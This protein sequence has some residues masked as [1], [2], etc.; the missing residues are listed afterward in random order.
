MYTGI[1]SRNPRN[2][3]L[4]PRNTAHFSLS[5]TRE[6]CVHAKYLRSQYNDTKE[7]A[8]FWN[9]ESNKVSTCSQYQSGHTRQSI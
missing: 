8:E 3:K 5:L 1:E 6:N 2:A 7:R 4:K 9:V